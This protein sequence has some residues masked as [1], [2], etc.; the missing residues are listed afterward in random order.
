MSTKCNK[1]I[2]K[3]RKDRDVSSSIISKIIS[4]FLLS[5]PKYE[6]IR[7][8]FQLLWYIF[9]LLLSALAPEEKMN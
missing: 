3:N 7:D 1:L 6:N 4:F 8:L 9:D 5:Q 2:L